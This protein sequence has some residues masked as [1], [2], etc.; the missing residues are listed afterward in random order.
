[1]AR[2]CWC[3]AGRV[4]GADVSR[5]KAADAGKILADGTGSPRQAGEAALTRALLLS[6]GL[7]DGSGCRGHAAWSHTA[8]RKFL[9]SVYVPDGLSAL[10]YAASDIPDLVAGAL[11]QVGTG[12]LP[13]IRATAQRLL[14]RMHVRL[15]WAGA[16][17]AATGPAAVAGPGGRRPPGADSGSVAAD[18]LTRLA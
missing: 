1:M 16:A 11:P 15:A 14:S 7:T 3:G 18:V 9:Q 17:A 12:A 4:P 6:D 10:G 8:L 2:A 13:A 5:A